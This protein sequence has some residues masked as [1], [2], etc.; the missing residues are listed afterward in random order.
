MKKFNYDN[1]FEVDGEMPFDSF[2]NLEIMLDREDPENIWYKYSDEN[3]V[4]S[5]KII[6]DWLGIKSFKKLDINEM[7]TY[8]IRNFTHYNLTMKKE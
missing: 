6:T 1:K 5:A 4:Y 2:C 7:G 8:E 3:Y